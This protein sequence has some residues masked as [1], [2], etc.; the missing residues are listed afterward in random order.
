LGSLAACHVLAA[1]PTG[2]A[3]GIT[4]RLVNSAK[5][6]PAALSQAEKQAAYIFWKAGVAPAWQDFSGV[7]AAGQSGPCDSAF[8]PTDF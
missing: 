5:V 1:A 8:G 7:S 3:P 4:V 6:P 2:A